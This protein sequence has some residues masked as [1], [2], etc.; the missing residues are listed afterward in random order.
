MEQIKVIKKAL[1]KTSR[2]GHLISDWVNG[3]YLAAGEAGSECQATKNSRSAAR[4]DTR[5]GPVN[6]HVVVDDVDGDD[7][8]HD[9]VDIDINIDDHNDHGHDQKP[10]KIS[11]CQSVYKSAQDQ[12]SARKEVWVV[13]EF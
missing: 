1:N 10:G 6:L 2:D 7:H 9:D 12:K 5:S 3:T 4:R 11:C 8:N 13:A